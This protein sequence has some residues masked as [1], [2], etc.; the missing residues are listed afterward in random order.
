MADFLILESLY[1]SSRCNP[2]ERQL[3]C[4]LNVGC[5]RDV[6][7]PQACSISSSTIFLGLGWVLHLL[8]L[9]F[10]AILPDDLRCPG[11]L[12]ADDVVLMAESADDLK[13]GSDACGTMGP[14]DGDGMWCAKCGIMLV[15]T[16]L[17]S[18]SIA[19]LT[20][21]GP[22]QLH[23]QDVPIVDSYRYLSYGVFQRSDAGSP[24]GVAPQKEP[25]R[26]S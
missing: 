14:I 6:L 26:P 21:L 7:C 15:L 18:E 23:G 11:L 20:N 22:W 8:E 24:H 4:Q 19:T 5:V 25:E 10:L 3:R 2:E 16:T 13:G 1:G 9:L 17:P 12:F